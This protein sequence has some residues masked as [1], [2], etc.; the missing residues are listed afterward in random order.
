MADNLENKI[1]DLVF[2][3]L[4]ESNVIVGIAERELIHGLL[5]TRLTYLLG[6]KPGL[7]TAQ[8]KATGWSDP[9]NPPA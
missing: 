9:N 8:L 4:N 1:L 7:T 6:E 2:R 5:T 3:T